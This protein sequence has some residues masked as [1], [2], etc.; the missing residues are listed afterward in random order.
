MHSLT[1]GR[2]RSPFWNNT[3]HY[4]D[5]ISF[6]SW[7]FSRSNRYLAKRLSIF[8]STMPSWDVNIL[9]RRQMYP[10]CFRASLTQDPKRCSAAAM[11]A[12]HFPG[13]CGISVMIIEDLRSTYACKE[14]QR[15]SDPLVFAYDTPDTPHPKLRRANFWPPRA[16]QLMTRLCLH[17]EPQCTM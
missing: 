3:D 9:K 4:P 5:T 17:Q 10:S 6:A 2:I 13:V 7:R 1:Q 11:L 16:R 15:W 12:L 8:A 14:G